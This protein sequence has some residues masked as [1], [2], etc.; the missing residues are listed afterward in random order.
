MQKFRIW[1]KAK[2]ICSF[3]K[4]NMPHHLFTTQDYGLANRLRGYLGAWA[5]AQRAGCILDVLWNESP[6][7]PYHIQELF[8][9]LPNTRF[10]TPTDAETTEY[11]YRTSDHGH[12]NTDI[13]TILFGSLKPVETIRRK[14]AAIAPSLKNAIGFHVRRTDHLEYAATCGGTTP[15]EVFFSTADANPMAPIFLACDEPSTLVTFRNKYGDRVLTAKDFAATPT[16]S[17]RY[18]DGEHAVL[19]LYCLAQCKVFRGTR[20]SLF[21]AHVVMVRLNQTVTPEKVVFAFSLYGSKKKYTEGMII[22]SQ[23]ITARFPNARIQ[24]YVADDVPKDVVERLSSFLSVRLIPVARSQ[25]SQNMFNRFTAIDDPDCDILFSRDADS[26]VHDRDA[27]CI[28]DFIA[29]DKLLHIIRDHRCHWVPILGGM[30]GIRKSALNTPLQSSITSWLNNNGNPTG[31][32]YDQQFLAHVI[33]PSLVKHAMIHDSIGH[34]KQNETTFQPFRVPIINKLF[35]GQVH[36]FTEE[37]EEFLEC[38]IE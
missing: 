14:L 21:S 32:G 18:T 37:G 17:L 36:D 30:W 4:N 5:H 11:I 25:G 8:E 31:Y 16:S 22:N 34:F 35:V 26:R 33:Y 13:A 38:G 29:S 15:L 27:A 20:A 2:A 24:I 7:C 28:E 10:I 23:Q 3:I 12:I 6:A 9:P 1:G 19:D